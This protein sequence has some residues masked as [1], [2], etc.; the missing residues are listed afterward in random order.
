MDVPVAARA[1]ADGLAV[2]FGIDGLEFGDDGTITLQIDERLLL[3]LALTAEPEGLI[4]FAPLTGEPVSSPALLRRALLGNFLWQATGGA[5]L[6]V[7]PKG[8]QLVLQQQ[9]PLAGLDYP[10]FAALLQTFIEQAEAW[11]AEAALGTDEAVIV[12]DRPGL[13]DPRLIV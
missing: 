4:L 9:V 1:I 3:S 2:N 10:A 8:G 7:E 13:F 11:S 6:S 5:T 12:Q